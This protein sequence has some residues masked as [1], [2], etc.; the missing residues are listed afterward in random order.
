M[1]TASPCKAFASATTALLFGLILYAHQPRDLF[2]AY[3]VYALVG[4]KITVNV[5]QGSWQVKQLNPCDGSTS[6]LGI[7]SGGQITST[8]T[9]SASTD[10]AS[11]EQRL[12][13]TARGH[14]FLAPHRHGVGGNEETGQ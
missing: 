9:V 12:P 8:V 10:P 13:A 1:H 11:V 5:P 7:K 2:A 4:G 3:V 14:S 6:D